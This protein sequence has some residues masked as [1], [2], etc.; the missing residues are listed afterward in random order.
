MMI[1]SDTRAKITK[2]LSYHPSEMVCATVAPA[3]V[4]FQRALRHVTHLLGCYDFLFVKT[5]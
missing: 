4:T 1:V 5:H 2:G 3:S